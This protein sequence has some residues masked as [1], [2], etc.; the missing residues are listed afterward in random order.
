MLFG[1]FFSGW[2]FSVHVFHSCLTHITDK[3]ESKVSKLKVKTSYRPQ[4][5]IYIYIYICIYTVYVCVYV[6]VC[7]CV[8]AH[9]RPRRIS[10]WIRIGAKQSSAGKARGH[11]NTWLWPNMTLACYMAKVGQSL[12]Y[13][14][15]T[16][17]NTP[18]QWKSLILCFIIH[19]LL[20]MGYVQYLF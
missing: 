15:R 4:I 16:L 9:Y 8:F 3:Q 7:V 18:V 6:G 10:L 17:S 11:V 14:A 13:A 19:L 1:L 12:F 20:I 5:Y 2:G